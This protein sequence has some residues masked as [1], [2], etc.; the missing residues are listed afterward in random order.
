M[1]H[2]LCVCGIA[3]TRMMAGHLLKEW[4]KKKKKINVY[5]FGCCSYVIYQTG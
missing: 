1:R 5:A 4:E 2:F 3:E